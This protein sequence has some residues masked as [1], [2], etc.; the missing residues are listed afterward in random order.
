MRADALFNHNKI[1]EA[2][3]ELFSQ[4]GPGIPLREIAETAHVGIGTLYRHFPNRQALIEGVITYVASSLGATCKKVIADWD[5]NPEQQWRIF[6]EHVFAMRTAV[7]F[8]N[9]Y[10]DPK[11]Q[12]LLAEL[13]DLTTD[14]RKE[15]YELFEEIL[16]KARRDG[17]TRPNLT[18]EEFQALCV[19]CT[20]KPAIEM[21]IL[22][23]EKNLLIDFFIAGLR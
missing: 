22:Q 12:D 23:C 11:L 19:I 5:T 6:I 20:R 9:T 7:I 21:P 10:I 16:A 1:L 8:S 2:A 14:T 4:Q 15:I 13:R 17:I 18:F 3:H